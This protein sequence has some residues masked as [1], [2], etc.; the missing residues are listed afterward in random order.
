MSGG[1]S[2]LLSSFFSSPQLCLISLFSLPFP[3]TVP[4]TQEMRSSSDAQPTR[5]PPALTVSPRRPPRFCLRTFPPNSHLPSQSCSANVATNVLFF[6]CSLLP[7][8]RS[9]PVSFPF[10]LRRRIAPVDFPLPPMKLC[11]WVM[12]GHHAFLPCPLLALLAINAPFPPLPRTFVC[13]SSLGVDGFSLNRFANHSPHRNAA[14]PL[15]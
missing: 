3:V 4:S 2:L 10:L 5:A 7:L 9:C 13:S 8:S 6:L 15:S 1:F 14:L 12:I 11:P